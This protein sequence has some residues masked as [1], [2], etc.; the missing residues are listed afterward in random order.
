MK[1]LL[2]LVLTSFFMRLAPTPPIKVAAPPNEI[3]KQVT[4]EAKSA[5][6]TPVVEK[7]EQVPTPAPKPPVKA[8]TPVVAASG[9]CAS[10]LQQAGISNPDAVWLISKESGCRPTAQ[11]PTS[12]AYGIFQFL[13]STWAGVGCVKTS[14]PVQQMIC[15]ERY[16]M[17]RYG[18]W[19]NTRAFWEVNHWY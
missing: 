7:T 11:N 9:D 17:R 4:I 2:T 13:D 8:S 10:W 1:L 3:K 19:A 16:I 14:D 18:S 6:V 15:G 12:S 5:P